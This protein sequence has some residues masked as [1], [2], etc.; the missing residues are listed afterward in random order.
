MPSSGLTNRLIPLYKAPSGEGASSFWREMSSKLG[1]N[2][3]C[4]HSFDFLRNVTEAIG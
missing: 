1:T 3:Q 4:V 2:A